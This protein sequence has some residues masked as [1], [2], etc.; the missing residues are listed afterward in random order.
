M[1][2][3]KN[4]RHAC[5]QVL[6]TAKNLFIK[7]NLK[8]KG[9][10]ISL[11]GNMQLKASV[12]RYRCDAGSNLISAKGNTFHG[13][14]NKTCIAMNKIHGAAKREHAFMGLTIR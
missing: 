9:R 1:Y 8:N 2:G 13:I 7:G 4:N 14:H 11:A 3:V 6:K 12:L 10:H 5:Y